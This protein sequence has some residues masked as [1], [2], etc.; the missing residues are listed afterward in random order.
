LS[1]PPG[2]KAP[3]QKSWKEPGTTHPQQETDKENAYLHN[4]MK[5][6]E[7]PQM[8]RDKQGQEDLRISMVSGQP[9]GDEPSRSHSD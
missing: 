8:E 6:K 1:H 7:Q 4:D 2:K 9:S 3:G 5:K